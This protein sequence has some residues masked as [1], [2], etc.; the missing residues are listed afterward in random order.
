MPKTSVSVGVIGAGLSG[1][2]MGIQL[3]RAGIDDFVIYEKAG[4]VGGTWNCNTWPGLHC[5]VP[6]HLYAYSFEPNANWS[7]LYAGQPE[8]KAY[9]RGCAEKY[10]LFDHLRL[11]TC[12]EK[13]R[14]REEDG[15]WALEMQDG[16]TA[17]HRVV[18]SATGGLTEPNLPPIEGFDD[19]QGSWFHSAAWRHD[20]DLKD[21]R[22]AVVGSAASAVT[23]VP[24]VASLASKLYVFQRTPN[25]I[26]PRMNAAY[27]DAAKDA[28]ARDATGAL[29]KHR[30]QLYRRSLVTYQAHKKQPAAIAFLR[31]VGMHNMKAHIK[32]PELIKRLTPDHDPGCKRIL[33]ADDFYPAL[34]KDHVELVPEG[35][36][37]LSQNGA[38]TVSG[39]EVEVDAVIFCTGYKLGARADGRP[40]VEVAGRGGV[41]LMQSLMSRPESYRGVA[42]SGFPNYFTV[43]GLNGVVAYTALFASAEVETDYIV[44]RIKDIEQHNLRSI[45]IKPEVVRRYNDAIQPELQ[46]MSW[47]GPCQNF[48]RD[49][50]G[51]GLSFYP[52]TLGRMRREFRKLTLDDYT[53][54]AAR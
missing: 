49:A 19:F 33:I 21:K 42:F 17:N 43:C 34:A 41:T 20:Y 6:S 27:D 44:K 11:G 29:S 31:E 15:S 5:D 1:I 38:A 30:Q 3:K 4:D 13:A 37:R 14:Y 7:L 26:L 16:S 25:W 18:V 2:L 10:G 36:A 54:E 53:V 22:V 52:G 9:L 23:V 46:K 45:E 40:A 51:R 50:T 12:I 48:Y 47:T 35:I 24:H 39:R 32:N 8:I 28:F